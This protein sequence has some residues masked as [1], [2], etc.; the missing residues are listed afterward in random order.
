MNRQEQLLKNYILTEI[1]SIEK[2]KLLRE[3]QFF[4][5]IN[6][7]LNEG[8]LE[9]GIVDWVKKASGKVKEFFLG[10]QDAMDKIDELIEDNYEMYKKTRQKRYKDSAE[11]QEKI[12]DSWRGNVFRR[13]VATTASGMLLL[14]LFKLY[15]GQP[16][17]VINDKY[18]TGTKQMNTRSDNEKP[19]FIADYLI[20]L[21]ANPSDIGT[22]PLDSYD[23]KEEEEK[24][25]GPNPLAILFK[26]LLAQDNEIAMMEEEQAK[27][28]EEIR[29]QTD[30]LMDQQF[31]SFKEILDLEDVFDSKAEYMKLVHFTNQED[32]DE[33][34]ELQEKIDK[35]NKT[36]ED[37]DFKRYTELLAE[38][39]K[40]DK[41]RT[42]LSQGEPDPND[43]YRQLNNIMYDLKDSDIITPD[44]KLEIEEIM[45]ANSALRLSQ[46]CESFGDDEA[47]KAKAKREI[48]TKKGWLDENGEL[49]DTAGA[50]V[51]AAI[52]SSND[53][54]QTNDEWMDDY[55]DGDE[56]NGGDSDDDGFD[57]D[58]D[59]GGYDGGYDEEYDDD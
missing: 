54:D 3:Q 53:D 40:N 49:T 38:D 16:V 37:I 25:K 13:N 26:E 45:D 28:R 55:V 11:S 5:E 30:Q 34:P 42:G 8:L 17:Q 43:Y 23:D 35:L 20:D 48:F 10:D 58:E 14:A 21:G 57:D 18:N 6:S 4:L 27:K 46:L 52:N 31:E 51:I 33:N 15:P 19:K 24:D 12:R 36:V 59:D 47:T 2:N 7:L 9:E 50:D 41:S 39:F 1:Y 29:N 56:D 32:L 44:A 22:T